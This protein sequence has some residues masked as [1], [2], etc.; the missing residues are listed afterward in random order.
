[1]C[2]GPKCVPRFFPTY[3][4]NPASQTFPLF[5]KYQLLRY[6]PLQLTQNN[7]LNDLEPC[8]QVFIACW[9]EFLHTQYV[10]NHVPQWSDKLADV[11][12]L[13]NDEHSLDDGLSEQNQ[14]IEHEDWMIISDFNTPFSQTQINTASDY[15]WS[16]DRIKYTDELIGDMPNWITTKKAL[17]NT[18]FYTP[19]TEF[20]DT[21]T[22]SLMQQKAYN[23][24]R[25][26][27]EQLWPKLPLFLI[28]IGVGGTGKSYVIS[29]LCQMLQHKS[30]IAAPTGKAAF[31][32]KGVTLHSLLK[33]PVGQKGHKDLSGPSLVQIQHQ[34]RGIEYIIIDEYS[35]LGQTLFGWIDKRLR[36][37]TGHC[38]EPFGGKSVVLIGDPGQL[39]PV[40]DKPLYHSQPSSGVAE[41][42]RCMY[43][44]F[45]K[46]VRLQTKHRVQGSDPKHRHFRNLLERLC[47]GDSTVEDWKSL[48]A[49]QPLSVSN[50]D[51]F[52]DAI[53][54]YFRNEDVKNYNHEKLMALNQPIAHI[55]A[56][57]S[58]PFAKTMDPDELS[59]LEPV[60]SI[61]KGAK[62]MLT[63]NLWPIVGL[64]NGAN[65][66]I[67]DIIYQIN[68]QPP[69]NC[70]YS[71]I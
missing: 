49:R 17:C 58:T 51:D 2:Q 16:L 3:S 50:I 67:V 29:A 24:V 69:S 46:V 52:K 44:L 40:G 1:M 6:K 28:I 59:L 25:N 42:G 30:A 61:A 70:C 32:V 38:D 18:N 48:L 63:M 64:C 4:S 65:G 21:S 7:A 26:H 35:M 14:S 23:I 27:A 10:Q 33:L 31:N 15:N 9:Q 8:N 60:I 55:N 62:V 57:H 20:V 71:T 66:A 39:P 37:I 22:F 19:L 11:A 45:D 5:C 13:H 34:I 12:Q 56:H 54:L 36:Q 41:Q 53:R 68:H 43:H 47:T